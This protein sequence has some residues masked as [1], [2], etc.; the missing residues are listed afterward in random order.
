[1][2]IYTY[3]CITY[4]HKSYTIYI[5]I[6]VHQGLDLDS[7]LHSKISKWIMWMALGLSVPAVCAPD[8]SK[9]L[10]FSLSLSLSLSSETGIAQKTCVFWRESFNLRAKWQANSL[11]KPKRINSHKHREETPHLGEQYRNNSKHLRSE[12]FS[13][14]RQLNH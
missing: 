14:H 5:Y 8:P 6:Y 3:I 2:Y 13:P 10:L 1:M 4:M 11:A 12:T 7:I 9:S